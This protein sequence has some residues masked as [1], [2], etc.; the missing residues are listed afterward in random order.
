MGCVAAARDAT[1][2]LGQ[3]FRGDKQSFMLSLSLSGQT[4]EPGK[5]Y[6]E[7]ALTP[8]Q[9]DQAGKGRDESEGAK[10]RGP[11]RWEGLHCRIAP[12]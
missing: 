5:A 1:E 10:D 11:A 12:C 2:T 6:K 3:G 9:A 4:A 7:S 8:Y